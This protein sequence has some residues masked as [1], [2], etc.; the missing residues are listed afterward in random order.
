M[1]WTE[2][3]EIQRLHVKQ[4]E[5]IQTL[6]VKLPRYMIIALHEAARQHHVQPDDVVFGALAEA[7]SILIPDK[8][9][10]GKG[11]PEADA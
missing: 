1:N 3:E 6:N 2:V 8:F 9:Q 7:F 4:M 5:E 11:R 10:F